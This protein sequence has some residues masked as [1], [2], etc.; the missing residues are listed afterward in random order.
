[1]AVFHELRTVNKK[2]VMN[3][4]KLS[5]HRTGSISDLYKRAFDRN[6]NSQ[7]ILK[8]SDGTFIDANER[9][10]ELSGFTREKILS[11]SSLE[12]GIFSIHDF[13][14]IKSKLLLQ[15]RVSDHMLKIK[16]NKGREVE[17]RLYGEVVEI[18]ESVYLLLTMIDT[19]IDVSH[20]SNV[21]SSRDELD[22]EHELYQNHLERLIQIRSQELLEHQQQFELAESLMDALMENLPDFIYFKDAKSRFI[23]V[24]KSMID[25][26][27][28]GK[29]DMIG[30]TDFD[31][32]PEDRAQQFFKD[33]QR[34]MTTKQ[35]IYNDLVK[36]ED[37]QG[38]T[39]WVST[40]KMP[41]VNKD[42]RVLG[43]FGIS[44]DVT[45]LKRSNEELAQFAYVASHDLQEPLRKIKNYTELLEVKYRDQLD[46]KG[47]KYMSVITSGTGRMQGLISDLL[48]Y[49]RVTSRGGKM[50]KFGMDEVIG[51]VRSMLEVKINETKAVILSD[52]L[53][54][55]LADRQQMYQLFQN[56]IS[57]A[58]KFRRDEDPK[59]QIKAKKRSR[60]WL[61]TVS[62][63]GIGMDMK[64]SER[65]FEVF[66]RL[67]TREEFQG[68][69]IGLAVVKKI[70]ERHQ[71]KI[72][73]ESEL[74]KGT[75]FLF[76]IPIKLNVNFTDKSM[77]K[78]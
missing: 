75:T 14:E 70:V 77:I 44:K 55:I 15:G 1:M 56:L 4:T 6:L 8:L 40:T 28:N 78:N 25:R 29:N 22:L 51:E 18:D 61:F 47:L 54:T 39:M 68:T 74:G 7:A 41:L 57:N 5:M 21:D 49:S 65:I 67:H 16:V 43:S 24:S 46:E 64:F 35:P 58:L 59:I 32:H 48:T 23:R 2:S 42:G 20:E 12:L 26:F 62:D 3:R 10:I 31:I 52:Q 19:P 69:G 30:K 72:W 9:F 73:V 17:F 45:D 63:N 11:T 76:T 53:P 37:G 38:K 33:E 27:F 66:Q 34:I 50:E 71:G 13:Q 60:D 36:E